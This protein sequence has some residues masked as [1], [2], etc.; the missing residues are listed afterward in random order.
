MGEDD[1]LAEIFHPNPL[2]HDED[3]DLGVS[4]ILH[5]HRANITCTILTL[6]VLYSHVCVGF[7]RFRIMNG[8]LYLCGIQIQRN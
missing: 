7:K 5:K 1:P 2:V 3:D 6:H 8:V 4:L